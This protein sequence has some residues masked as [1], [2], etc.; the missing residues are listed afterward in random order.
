MRRGYL[1]KDPIAFVGLVVSICCIV[2]ITISV[3][4]LPE[5]SVVNRVMT[6]NRTVKSSKVPKDVVIGKFGEMMIEMLP[7]DLAFTVFIPSEK[8]FE[9]DLRLRVNDSLSAENRNDTYAVVSRI[10]GF[11]AIPR[12]LLSAMVYLDKEVSYD[13]VSGFPLYISKDED[14]MVV[15]NRI[16]SEIVDV[17]REEVIVYIM[18]GVIMDAEFEQSVEPDDIED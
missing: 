12:T 10:M 17:K 6:S 14:G 9:R 8:A 7:G 4:K 11:S 5:V 18:D 2:I 3:L 16:R 1:L 13:S 15:V